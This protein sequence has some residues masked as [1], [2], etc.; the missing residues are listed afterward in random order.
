MKEIVTYLNFDGNCRDAMT[1]YQRCLGG[2]LTLAT[3]GEGQ[4]ALPETVSSRIMHA[5]L[6]NGL[7]G[8]MASD[9]MP[10]MPRLAGN[11][12]SVSIHCESE[13]EVDRLYAALAEGG[14]S[15]ML[16][17]DAPWGARF[18]M[19]TDKFGIQWMFNFEKPR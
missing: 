18:G 15:T 19:L 8:L 2:E 10:G 7:A 12:F 17:T 3:F 6:R 11:N 5:G 14:T 13:D 9:T 16:P 4:P 1:F